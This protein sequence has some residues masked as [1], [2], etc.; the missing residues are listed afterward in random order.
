MQIHNLGIDENTHRPSATMYDVISEATR[1]SV[2][3]SEQ[4]T[5]ALGSVGDQVTLQ[6]TLTA[7]NLKP[8]QYTLHIR[9]NDKISNQTVEPAA[10]FRVE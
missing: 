10:S 4:L 9:V 8:G 6:K 3:H 2:I 7:A 1:K 5:S